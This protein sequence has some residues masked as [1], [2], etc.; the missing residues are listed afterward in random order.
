MNSKYLVIH[1]ALSVML[2]FLQ[3]SCK[4][5]MPGQKLFPCSVPLNL[6]A[7]I[8]KQ[9][10]TVSTFGYTISS[11]RFCVRTFYLFSGALTAAKNRLY[12][13]AVTMI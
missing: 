1:F 10:H 9:K 7:H 5:R 13:R 8:S 4:L 12:N 11:E 2:N 3:I 6:G